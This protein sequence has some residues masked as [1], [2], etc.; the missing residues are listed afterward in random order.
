MG[1][2][3]CNITNCEFNEK[4]QCVYCGDYWNLNDENCI[5]FMEKIEVPEN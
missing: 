4:G 3:N 5:S 2:Y 1:D